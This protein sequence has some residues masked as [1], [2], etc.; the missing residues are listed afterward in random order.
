MIM[1]ALGVWCCAGGA[2][3]ASRK[4]PALRTE[5]NRM[6]ELTFTASGSYSDP[7]NEV[8]LDVVFVDPRGR[9]LRVPGFWAGGEVWKA[10]YASPVVGTHRFR[11]ECSAAQDRG[12][13]GVTGQVEVQA[14]AGS[15]PLYLHGPLQVSPNKRYLEHADHTPFFWLGDTWWMGLCHRLRWPEEFQ[16]LAADRKEKGFNVI[17]IVAGLYPDMP[18]F[19]PRG[20]NEAGFPWETDYARIRPQYFD[21]ADQ[22]LGYLV[23]QGL[24]PCIVGAWGYFMPWMGVEKMKAHWRYLIARY[25]AWPVVWAAAGEANLPWYLAKGFPYDDRQQV[26]DW[27]EVM[28]FI[29]E[30][31][32][33]HR[34][35]TVHPT[36]INRYTAR[37]ATDDAGLLDIDMLQTPHGQREAVPVVVNAVRQSYAAA[38]VL[39]VI[40]GEASYEMLND[41]LP[42]EW[43]RR[44][45]WLCLM[46]GAAGHTY[47]ANGIWQCNRPG[48]P[49]GQSP[50]GGTYG[51]IPWNEAMRLPGSRQVG[52]GKQ[53]LEQYPWQ[54]FRPHPEWVAFAR[55]SA[56]SFEGCRWVWFPEG[57]PA[58]DAPV[59]KR[60]FRREFVL[61]EGKTITQARLRVSADD[62]F[63]ARLNGQTLGTGEDWHTGKQFEV[64][65]LLR[66]GTN[67]VAVMAENKPTNVTA[68]PAGLIGCLEV[69]FT[70]NEPVVKL[71]SDDAW[72]CARSEASGWE[73]VGFDDSGWARAMV[74][75]RYGD[76]PWGRLDEAPDE[77]YGPQ[78]TGIPGVVRV[79]YVPQSMAVEVRRLVA[80]G[81]Y[82]ATCFDPVS[83]DKTPL[84]T[85]RADAAGRWVC[86]PP[87]GKDHD[88][89]LLLDSLKPPSSSKPQASGEDSRSQLTLANE[90]MAWRLDW[91]TGPLRSTFVENKLSG[92]RFSLSGGHEIA[93]NFSAAVDRVAQPFTRVADWEVRASR[94][95]GPQHGEF[96]LRS[97]TLNVAV[98]LHYELDGATRRKWAVVTNHSGQEL[99]LLD[100]ELD[101]LTT[102]GTTAGG[103]QGQ[104]VFVDDE[105]WAAIEHPAGV[106]TGEKGRIQLAHYPGRRLG[107]EAAF[108]SQVALFS[109][110]G[111]GQAQ[112]AFIS[113]IQ[114]KSLRPKRALSIYT[115][116]GINNQWGACPTLDDEQTLDVLGRLAE[117][118]KKGVRF[119]YFTL[120]T[121]WVDPNSNLTRF[122]PACYPNGPGKIIERANALGMKF[123]L[124]F[125]TSWAAESCWDYPPAL[126]GQPQ[127]SMP[128]R[129]GYPDKAHEG[130][131]FCFASEAYYQTLKNAV[132]YHVVQNK[133][134]LIKLDGGNYTCES[135]EHGHLPGK[136]AVELMYDHLIDIASSARAAAPDVFIMWY[137]G[138]RSS[139]WALHGD[140]IF[141]S[142]LWMEGSATSIYPTLYY[143]DSVT[144]A[145][146]QNAQFAKTIPPVVKDSLGVWL[147]DNRWG[148]FM[149]KERWREALVMDLGRG[150]LFVPNLWGNPYHLSDAD[151]A[152]LARMSQFARQNESLFLHRRNLPGDPMRNDVYGYA[153]CQGAC[154]F[155]FLNNAHFTARRAE[156]CL[157]GSIGL[158]AKP[159]TALHVVSHFPEPAR[160][161]RPDGAGFK[162]GD[163]LGIWLRPFEVLM[164][165]VGPELRKP[166]SAAWPVRSISRPQAADL[167]AALALKPVPLDAQMQMC[168]ADA[169]AFE[170]QHL[171]KKAYAFETTLPSLS[172]APPVLAVAIR[173]RQ[174]EAEWRHAPT[175]VQIVQALARIGAQNVQ[176]VPVPDGRQFGNTQSGGSSWV[177]YKLR[178]NPQWSHQQ[179]KLAVHACLPDGVEAQ[180]EA[181]LVKQWWQEEA[182]PVGDGYYN[183]AP[184]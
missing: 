151:V 25:G 55:E 116:F 114:S 132:L 50:H 35:L 179:L 84:G 108:S 142:G 152:F 47:G 19:D 65:R 51:K 153:D 149:D 180:I 28:R 21:A 125:A 43:T 168:F 63:S 170:S 127:I 70:E 8:T 117:W 92:H 45:F 145:Q 62:W 164:L 61:P 78:A 143:R 159:G 69:R 38:P 49:H 24:T 42:T 73:S 12:L 111:A 100:V 182:R 76:G 106:N 126:A 27:T 167:G 75:G 133:V 66:P 109:V 96:D 178:L 13:H 91:S 79:I 115:P 11:S 177:L 154:G 169:A 88:W 120:D 1:L 121:G 157:D 64:A 105:V 138:L 137:W 33:F 52:L 107:P 130:H 16:Q 166:A 30:T 40:D 113:Y 129:L 31:D 22:R 67:V 172:G 4:E 87:A 46:N 68:N 118:Q 17:Q 81:A 7:F 6:V 72:R 150:N 58:Q 97:P 171:R 20:A 23:E 53:L 158:A 161:L 32:P 36:A 183:D 93:L 119:D 95:V 9:E 135:T 94:V 99:L 128:Y 85:I 140:L 102:D 101:D 60:F 184:S 10:R 162:A 144:L 103:G 15:N 57:N 34:P 98:T 37:H 3:G 156:V 41:S 90:Q 139:F 2:L 54:Q 134:R 39:T 146:D 59:A 83:G 163:A 77:S 131:M 80:Q 29:R 122:R 123:G 176:M 18:A 82:A 56:L 165:E 124:W 86:P 104:P 173:L 48:D 175:V 14:Y 136:Y 112:E 71:V 148:N 147:A 174:G 44:M 26:H 89:V 74:V 160:L 155:L 110:A 5:A 141:E 181:W